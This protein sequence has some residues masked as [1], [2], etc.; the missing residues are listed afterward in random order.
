MRRCLCQSWSILA[1]ALCITMPTTSTNTKNAAMRPNTSS[2]WTVGSVKPVS[3]VSTTMPRISSMTAAPRI[4]VPTLLLSLPI[5]RRVSTVIETEV[6]VSTTPMNAALSMLF[7]SAGL[8]A[9][10]R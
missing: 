8:L 10:I 4:A 3:T 9:N 5:S 2:G 6:A 1:N 7:A